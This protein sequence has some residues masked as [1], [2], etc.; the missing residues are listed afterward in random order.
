MSARRSSARLAPRA[1]PRSDRDRAWRR[2][3][4]NRA[5]ATSPPDGRAGSAP[6]STSFRAKQTERAVGPARRCFSSPCSNFFGNGAA[7]QLRKFSP[8]TFDR[9][10]AFIGFARLPSQLRNKRWL[11]D[12]TPD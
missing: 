3:Y 6:R 11:L 4:S 12:E 5:P 7:N 8:E 10:T 9:E 2:E 1:F